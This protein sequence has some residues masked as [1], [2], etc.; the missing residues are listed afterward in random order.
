MECESPRSSQ[1]S[2]IKGRAAR[3]AHSLERE[4]GRTTTNDTRATTDAYVH[5]HAHPH[6]G[7]APPCRSEPERTACSEVDRARARARS[8]MA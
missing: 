1:D 6:D 3:P 2:I 4:P 5:A 7:A 8:G